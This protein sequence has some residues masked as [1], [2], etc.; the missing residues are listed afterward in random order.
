MKPRVRIVLLFVDGLGLGVPDPSVNPIVRGACPHLQRLLAD[1]A[2]PV[3]AGLGVPGTPQSAT[4]QTALLTGVNAAQA[5][6]RHVEGF[7]GEALR[8]IIREQNL[9]LQVQRAGGTATFA[10]GYYAAD[11][12]QV[13]AA[14]LLSVTTVA[15]LS[16][17]GSVRT[18]DFLESNRAVYQDLTRESLRERGYTGPLTTPAEAARHLI[19][20][21]DGYDLTLFEYFQTDRAGHRQDP[22]QTAAVL[23]RYDAF[24]APLLEHSRQAGD[25]LVVLTSDHGNIED[26]RG[27]GHTLNPVP[28]AAVGPAA[29]R[30]QRQVHSL[31]DVTP[32]LLSL[33][34]S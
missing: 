18:R 4:G 10:N 12:A 16:A 5:V 13:L 22:E 30:L 31:T 17:F 19:A 2:V 23:A 34:F 21:A 32:A 14:P 24:L 6:G 9:F 25:W 15:A 7:P 29:E 1:H 27:R 26:A 33:F 8:A 28:L 3:D 20:I 11:R